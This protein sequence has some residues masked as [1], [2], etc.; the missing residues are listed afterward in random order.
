MKDGT[1]ASK[2]QVTSAIRKVLGFFY[3]KKKHS[4]VD[5]MLVRLF[6]PILWRSLKVANPHVRRNAALML[7]DAFPL[8]TGSNSQS[9]LDELLQK[10]FSAIQALLEDTCVSVRCVAV[11]GVCRILNLFWE[12]IPHVT[13]SS[14]LTNL[15]TNLLFD[16]RYSFSRSS[17]R[18]S[19]AVRVAVLEG[20]EYLLDNHL[21]HSILKGLCL[22]R[23]TLTVLLPKVSSVIHDKAEKVRVAV[24]KLLST[25]KRVKM[26][27]FYDVVPIDHL[28]VRLSIDSPHIS[29]Q[30]SK[31]LLNSYFASSK[32]SS[33]QVKRC[34]VLVRANEEAAKKFYS[35]VHAMAEVPAICKFMGNIFRYTV[36]CAQNQDSEEADV[37]KSDAK[38]LAKLL[39]IVSILWTS[40]NSLL[41]NKENEEMRKVTEQLNLI[42]QYLEDAFQESSVMEV[43]SHMDNEEGKNVILSIIARIPSQKMP[44]FTAKCL[45]VLPALS[46]GKTEVTADS[47]RLL[48]CLF[49]WN[50]GDRVLEMLDTN[51]QDALDAGAEDEEP[52]QKKGKKSK[53]AQK[54]SSGDPKPVNGKCKRAL[55]ILNRLLVMF[56]WYLTVRLKRTAGSLCCVI[57]SR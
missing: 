11:S 50:L 40:I 23:L 30:I 38:E 8:Q 47:H 10:Q 6:E 24:L 37:N 12:L 15:F 4:G 26:I 55:E 34:I 45:K 39:S 13:T 52:K 7:I 25:I 36:K 53:G 32:S 21:S 1:H 14:L 29:E 18:S 20:V 28:L 41:E 43:Y 51:F 27:R 3:A 9:Q 2:S 44:I 54:K 17:S 22:L 56:I 31:L 57:R 48:A 46:S 5:E 19:S 42:L 49:A 33:V 16:A 35:H